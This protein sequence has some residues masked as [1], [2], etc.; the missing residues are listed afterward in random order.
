[1]AEQWHR[2]DRWWEYGVPCPFQPWEEDEPLDVREDD[3]DQ[4]LYPVPGRKPAVPLVPPLSGVA[5]AEAVAPVFP[6]PGLPP[7]PPPLG[8]PVPVRQPVPSGRPSYSTEPQWARER[9][10]SP[11]VDPRKR[12]ELWQP[13]T[14][15]VPVR[16]DLMQLAALMNLPEGFRVPGPYPAVATLPAPYPEVVTVPVMLPSPVPGSAVSPLPWLLRH[17]IEAAALESQFVSGLAQRL[18]SYYQS[19]DRDSV[20]STTDP[21][22]ESAPVAG[23]P[24]LTGPR[25]IGLGVAGAAAIGAGAMFFGGS[26]PRGGYGGRHMQF[27]AGQQLMNPAAR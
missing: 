12:G 26:Q 20:L 27:G 4:P 19:M 14:A 18:E 6:P 22:E 13:R 7:I 3:K 10:P 21:W 5:V 1:M 11:V 15:P 24:F 9:I 16:V 23:T 8:D 25:L 17:S 2:C